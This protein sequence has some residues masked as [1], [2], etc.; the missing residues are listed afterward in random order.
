KVVRA[1]KPYPGDQIT[2]NTY[3]SAKDLGR[4][5]VKYFGTEPWFRETEFLVPVPCEASKSFDLP[6][7]ITGQISAITRIPNAS[8]F[9]SVMR[10][11]QHSQK[12]LETK[13]E[14]RANVNGLFGISNNHPFSGKTV[15]IVDDI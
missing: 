9:V 3:A 4:G 14:K 5:M 10:Q 12:D 13:E 11:K 8:E 2:D 6:S 7:H 15:T 1:A